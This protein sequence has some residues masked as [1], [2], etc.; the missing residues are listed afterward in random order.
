MTTQYSTLSQDDLRRED[1]AAMKAEL[2][3]L[4]RQLTNSMDAV[5]LSAHRYEDE[6]PRGRMDVFWERLTEAQSQLSGL[7]VPGNV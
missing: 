2:D 7:T 1:L 4:L 6:I 3:G 5:I